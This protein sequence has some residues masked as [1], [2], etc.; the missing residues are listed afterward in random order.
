VSSVADP[1]VYVSIPATPQHV[2]VL[3]TVAGGVAARLDATLDEIEDLRLAVDEAA[4]G[5]LAAG[6]AATL[7]LSIDPS[8]RRVKVRMATD[9]QLNGQ[10]DAWSP[11]EAR[12]SFSAQILAALVDDLSFEADEGHPSITFTMPLG[13]SRDR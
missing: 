4:G 6:P 1:F 7:H 8:E 9:A 13:S 11:A 12:G 5:M 3:R 2:H 10:G